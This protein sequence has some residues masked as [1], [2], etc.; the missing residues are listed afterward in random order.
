MR[1]LNESEIQ[2]VSG[3]VTFAEIGGKIAQ[4]GARLIETAG[5]DT[6]EVRI[7]TRIR[8]ADGGGQRV[9]TILGPWAI[10]PEED[11]ISYESDLARD[12]LGRKAGDGVVVGGKSR[13][14]EKIEPYR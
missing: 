8:L 12:V 7:G 10:R 4:L 2:A 1:V 14:I 5:M 9:L 3:G 11:V 13:R 6:S